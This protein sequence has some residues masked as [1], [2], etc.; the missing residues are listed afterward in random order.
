MSFDHV[1]LCLA[2]SEEATENEPRC[3]FREL[4]GVVW[5]GTKRTMTIRELAACC[6]PVFWFSLDEPTVYDKEGKDI[7]VP[8]P[9]PFEE[10]PDSPVVYYQY[11]RILVREDAD[12]P[13]YI[14]DPTDENNSI[15]DLHN[16]AAINLKFIAYFH[17]EEGFGGH[18]H[19]VEPTE[20]KVFIA[21]SGGP[22]MD[23]YPEIKCDEVNCI[24]S[25]S[26]VIA[27]AHGIQWYFNTLDVDE[28]TKFPMHI[29]SEEG[30]HGMCTDKN[31]DGYYTPGYD[32]NR[33]VN[34]A[35]C[36]RDIIRSGALFTGGY[37][38]WMTKVRR[39]QHR[40]FPPL[41]EDSHLR[42]RFTIDGEY[43]S[44]NAIYELRAFPSSELAVDDALL[45]HKMEEKESPG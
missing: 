44:E 32:V 39:P 3:D 14:E 25:V 42:E 26:Q 18:P 19:D 10:N 31:S 13:A 12:G 4:S 30:K 17:A 9:L 20:F 11:N 23:D 8:D 29:L 6:A 21:W 5:W 28:Y 33:Y 1:G 16:A 43:A 45:K 2:R 24:V 15:I 27:E 22:W 40:V 36:C 37:R 38:T 41:P 34:D 35:W 7:R